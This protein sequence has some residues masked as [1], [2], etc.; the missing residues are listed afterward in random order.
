MPVKKKKTSPAKKRSSTAKRS[1]K[2]VTATA[3]RPKPSRK[4]PR[5]SAAKIHQGVGLERGTPQSGGLTRAAEKIG[6][7]I[8]ATVGM[9]DTAVHSAA[10]FG[11]R[12]VA[13][14]AHEVGILTRKL[15]TREPNR[16]RKR[17]AH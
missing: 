15:R 4:A 12:E 3:R 5:G 7:A 2:K 10:A 6:A 8:G 1:A 9:M 17:S 16:R 14:A 13:T 11:A